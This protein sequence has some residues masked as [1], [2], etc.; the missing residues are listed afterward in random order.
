MKLNQNILFVF[1]IKIDCSISD[2][3]FFS[4]LRD[5]GRKKTL[6]GKNLDGR[7]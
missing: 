6:D 2:T 1:K 3:G 4:N 5:C 7:F